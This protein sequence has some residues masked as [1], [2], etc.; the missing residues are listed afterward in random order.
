[1]FLGLNKKVKRLLH[2]NIFFD[3]DFYKHADDIYTNPKW[4]EEPCLY[5]SCTSITDTTVAPKGFENL[6]ILIPV[7]PGLED[8][9]EIKEFYLNLAINR[10]EKITGEQFR[11]NIIVKKIFAQSDFKSL[12]NAYKGNAYGLS[13]ILRQTG[14]L[15]PKIKN[16]KL[17]NFYYAGQLTVPGP[18]VPPAI[19]SGKIVAN[20]IL[21]FIR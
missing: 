10:I 17:S 12:F 7:A 3:T 6:V 5:V 20:E 13:N 9:E 11:E 21:R 8:N 16:R 18:G 15:K 14:V 2:H 1:M 19:L 4:P